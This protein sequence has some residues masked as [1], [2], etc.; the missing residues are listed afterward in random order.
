M[1]RRVYYAFLFL[2]IVAFIGAI[3]YVEMQDAI[4]EV[5]LEFL[6]YVGR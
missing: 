4:R 1:T 3:L 2:L 6:P 5:R